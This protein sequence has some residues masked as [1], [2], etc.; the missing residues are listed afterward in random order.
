MFGVP[1]AFFVDDENRR[2]EAASRRA[3][4]ASNA[5]SARASGSDSLPASRVASRATSRKPSLSGIEEKDDAD[6]TPARAVSQEAMIL[7]TIADLSL[8]RFG[9]KGGRCR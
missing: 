1:A 4:L 5:N 9:S 8:L 6:A 2:R 3:S 7:T